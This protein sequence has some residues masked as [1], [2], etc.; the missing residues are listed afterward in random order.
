MNNFERHQD[1]KKA[2]GIG[3]FRPRE[4]KTCSEAG[5][6]V[7]QNH[8]E[9]LKMSK[10]AKPHPTPEQ[11]QELRNYVE[12]CITIIDERREIDEIVD[13]TANLYRELNE[14]IGNRI[15]I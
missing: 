5:S 11:F 2:L 10:L 8:T 6:W 9:I 7:M 12:E 14:V 1:P 13:D 3:I 15:E 4:F